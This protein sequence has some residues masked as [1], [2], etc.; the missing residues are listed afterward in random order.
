MD[1][2]PARAAGRLA[3][4]LVALLA[5][6]CGEGVES[7]PRAGCDP[8]DDHGCPRGEHCRLVGDGTTICLAPVAR[9]T[10]VTCDAA[11]CPPG[12]S[13]LTFLG[14][15]TCRAVCDP[16]ADDCAGG[17]CAVEIEGAAWGA[18]VTTCG[19]AAGCADARETCAPVEGIGQPVCVP[20]GDAP[21]GAACAPGQCAVGT[22]CLDRD[23]QRTCVPVCDPAAPRCPEGSFCAGPVSGV[24]DLNYCAP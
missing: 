19:V 15:T 18:C 11:A 4:A 17:L 16:A 3:P 10:A 20:A 24:R 6:G 12:A 22:A 21:A 2:R 14:R 7:G 13:C 5:L 8:R 9:I 1:R 23:G